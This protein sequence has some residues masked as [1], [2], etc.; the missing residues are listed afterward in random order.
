MIEEIVKKSLADA[1]L[2]PDAS[3][4]NLFTKAGSIRELAPG[5]GTGK[6]VVK[7]ARTSSGEAGKTTHTHPRNL[8][9]FN[10]SKMFKL[11]QSMIPLTSG[12]LY[13]TNSTWQK[14][15][16]AF[17][18]FFYALYQGSKR[19]LTTG[20]AEVLFA[21]GY[22]KMFRV[23]LDTIPTHYQV[24]FGRE[25]SEDH[26]QRAIRNLSEYGIITVHP[27]EVRVPE[28]LKLEF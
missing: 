1:G 7:G 25:L 3:V 22:P 17:V 12:A 4:V 28:K 8:L 26:M 15:A 27:G 5:E 21:I 10:V 18:S 23:P 16:V 20:D 14:I 2:E 11:A 9:D 19:E 24:L 13:A 6:R